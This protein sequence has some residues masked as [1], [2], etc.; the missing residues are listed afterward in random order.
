MPVTFRRGRILVVENGPEYY[1]FV[2]ALQ[3]EARPGHPLAYR[4][5]EEVLA[6]AVTDVAALEALSDTVPSRCDD[7]RRL[8]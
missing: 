2:A 3:D 5:R 4:Q 6:M 1:G 7:T 8:H